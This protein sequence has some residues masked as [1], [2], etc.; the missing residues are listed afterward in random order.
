MWFT[1]HSAT[2]SKPDIVGFRGSPARSLTG[3]GACTPPAILPAWPARAVM[4][5]HESARLCEQFAN[6][7]V[8]NGRVAG[9]PAGVASR[10]RS[11][12]IGVSAADGVAPAAAR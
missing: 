11:K 5:F 8:F 3:G 12:V 7:K 4:I 1:A 2:V 10:S 9:A 6:S